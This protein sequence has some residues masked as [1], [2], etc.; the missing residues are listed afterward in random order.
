MTS[1][2]PEI[3]KQV[4]ELLNI[5]IAIS[6]ERN[7]DRLLEKI[8]SEARRITNADAGTLY[9]VEGN[10]L[11]FKI[12]QN[13]T[14]QVF[15]GGNGE[16]IDLPPVPLSLQNV[17]SYVAI[18]RKIV[19]IPDVYQ[20]EEFD[21]SGPKNYD[22]ITGYRT[23]SMLVIPLTNHEEEVIGVLQLINALDE[24]GNI[25]PFADYYEKI[26]LTLG[27]LAAIYLSNIKLINDIE[28][29]FTCFVEVMATAIDAQT[30]YNANHTRRVA[31]LAG[32]LARAVNLKSQ[33]EKNKCAFT[34]DE[35]KQLTMA[36]WLHDIGKI[37]VPLEVMNKAT[38]LEKELPLI[39]Q[40][41]DYIYA[42]KK[43]EYLEK[44]LHSNTA[45]NDE[46]IEKGWQSQANF[47][48]EAKEIIKRANDPSFFVD[49]DTKN[50][51]K[52]I[53]EKTYCDIEGR[54]HNWLTSAELE[55]LCVSKG[56]LTDR[57]RSIME[58]HVVIT[59]RMLEKMPFIKK[60]KEVP[61]F[62]ALHHEHLD[63]KGYP[64]GL[65]GDEIPIEARILALV[66]IF[67]ALTATDRPY[68]KP[69]PLN[70]ALEIMSFMVKEGKLDAELFK[71]FADYRVWENLN[72][73]SNGVA[74]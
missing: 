33:Q 25:I 26:I 62:A 14:M 30:P 64:Y 71:T 19:N 9:L 74:F 59:A 23:G 11:V 50:R 66:D 65:K 73:E 3:I 60:L 24:K 37:T 5:G 57:E 16:T 48:L 49:Q 2:T 58:E 36:G 34:D 21:F 31:A 27:S 1:Y 20:V 13:Q 42:A 15:R 39:M 18:T 54:R 72:E 56:T 47:I 44:K 40:R 52:S 43:C 46:E 22:R 28:N 68:K 12:M 45:N 61:R 67:D 29:L 41:L 4:E 7:S 55:A 6:S 10:R 69:I 35:I 70:K 17:S 32:E 8:V 38:R 51:L 63:G 53:A